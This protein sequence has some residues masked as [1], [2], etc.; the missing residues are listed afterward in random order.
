MATTAVMQNVGWFHVHAYLPHSFTLSLKSTGLVLGLKST[1]FSIGIYVY[2]LLNRNLTGRV[3]GSL[4]YLFSSEA[5]LFFVF[6]W[7]YI[8]VWSEPNWCTVFLICFIAFLY[9]FQVT[10]CP[11]S[12]ENTVPMRHL[13]FVTVYRWLSGM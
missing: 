13:V 7:P 6:C 12:G 1:Q 3:T 11:S 9:M 4:C 8:L 2:L 5:P 10:M